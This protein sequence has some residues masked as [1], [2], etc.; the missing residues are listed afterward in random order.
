MTNAE[1]FDTVYRE[2]R[3]KVLD[4]IRSHVSDARDAEDLCSEV[5][6]KALEHFSSER[7]EG[8]SSYIYTI[9]RNTVVD[10]YRT[11]RVHAP[12]DEE[13]PSQDSMEDALVTADGLEALAR[14]LRA[15]PEPERDLIVLH[16]YANNSLR[17]IADKME[18]SYGAA[19]RLH[20]SALRHLR[21]ALGEEP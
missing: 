2:Y 6:R 8:V 11:R 13:L 14:S 10:Y 7:G 20:Q 19:K 21:G 3:P 4:Y 9:T 1:W 5:F 18:L 17:E 12:L 15:L 16:Y